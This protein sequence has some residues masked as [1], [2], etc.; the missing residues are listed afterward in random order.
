MNRPTLRQLE[1]FVA[2][3]D[4]LSFSAA[5]RACHVSQPGLSDQ[6]RR[7]E[8][9]LGVRLF[10]RSR[11][12]VVPTP[13]GQ[14]LA[15][16][17]RALLT[18]A[19]DLQDAAASLAAPLT[20]PLRMGVIPTIAPYL[21]PRVMPGVRSHHPALRLLLREAQT[22]SLMASLAAGE[23]DLL[24]LALE[25]PLGPGVVTH[26]LFDDPFGVALP[27][28]HA[29]AAGEEGA[30]LTEAEIA[31]SGDPLLVLE[32]G[33]CLRDQALAACNRP[34]AATD[35]ADFRATSL[36]TL[37]QMVAGGQGVTL[38]PNLALPV[39]T[40]AAPELVVRPLAL[41]AGRTIGLAWRTTS[42]RGD[43][44]R[45]LGE[46]LIPGVGA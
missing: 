21:L 6:I 41:S 45:E 20:G 18:S 16:R 32:E 11:R 22:A 30:P 17:A 3:D 23:L 40:A 35:P 25:A 2:V 43:E 44:F 36:T 38:L 12:R 33:N 28:G 24:L 26:A 8:E 10:E 7:L 46:R 1:Y 5:A 39:E 19:R 13:A 37:V 9:Q 42:A 31:A 34:P 29:L 14:A 4:H 15:P 27:A